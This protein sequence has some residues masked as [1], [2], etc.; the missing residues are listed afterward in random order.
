[1]LGQS[2]TRRALTNQSEGKRE[3]NEGLP[4]LMLN[5]S[6]KGGH[7]CRGPDIRGKDFSSSLV[8]PQVA[9]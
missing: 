1:M 2:R 7:P 8:L 6:G 3:I 9:K 4:V 5:R